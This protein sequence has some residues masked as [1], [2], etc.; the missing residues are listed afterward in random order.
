MNRESTTTKNNE[1]M[2]ETDAKVA[3]LNAIISCFAEAPASRRSTTTTN[4]ASPKDDDDFWQST[5]P[6]EVAQR[7]APLHLQ[8]H[9]EDLYRVLHPALVDRQDKKNASAFLQGARGTGKSLVLELVLQALLAEIRH[10]N[11]T[12]RPFRIVRLHGILVPG[13]KVA[14]C[15]Q[16]ILRQLTAMAYEENEMSDQQQ[17]PNQDSNTTVPVENG[18]TAATITSNSSSNTPSLPPSRPHKKLRKS[19]RTRELLRLRKTCFTNQIQLL[20]EILQFACLDGIPILFILDELDAFVKSTGGESFQANK[21]G[22][23]VDRQLLLYHLLDRVATDSSLVSFVGI[24]C[25]NGTMSLLEKRIRSRAEGTTRFI[26]FGPCASWRDW[27]EIV[28]D[29]LKQHNQHGGQ[30]LLCKEWE[31]L[32][33]HNPNETVDKERQQILNC[34]R[35]SFNLGYSVR[36]LFRILSSALM[37]YRHDLIHSSRIIDNSSQETL[38]QTCIM[39]SLAS[40]GAPFL[41]ASGERDLIL[42]DKVAVNDRVQTLRDLSG[43]QVALLFA[44]RRILVRDSHRENT[45]P[46]SFE[47]MLEDYKTYKGNSNRYSRNILWVSFRDLL[48]TGLIR[49]GTDHTGMAPLQYNLD[50]SFLDLAAP[51]AGKV[52]LHLNLD[53]HREFQKAMD[54]KLLDCSA[55]LQEWGKKTT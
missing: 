53:I 44:A 25:H 9:F 39:Q 19:D 48:A 51:T 37:L 10:K 52:P 54:Q 6:A 36:W 33:T 34:F 24:T 27:V 26:Y 11:T 42:V 16:E 14:L 5:T 28:S 12:K 21:G 20:N 40:N 30:G 4:T 1:T 18:T 41:T 50:E 7:Y 3:E 17:E 32:V 22:D 8:S 38:L 45:V 29:K 43:P 55:A 31:A 35:R 23:A 2:Q 47:R 46:L 49:P 15:V 13:N